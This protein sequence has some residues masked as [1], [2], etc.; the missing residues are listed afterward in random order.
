MIINK[1]LNLFLINLSGDKYYMYFLQITFSMNTN[2]DKQN[3]TEGI[4]S[5]EENQ[6]PQQHMSILQHL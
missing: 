5:P 2:D 6:N 3:E 4:R 1:Y